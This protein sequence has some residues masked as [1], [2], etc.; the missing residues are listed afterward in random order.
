MI[1]GLIDGSATFWPELATHLWQSTLVLLVL[2]L[3]APALRGAPARLV[4]L[5]WWVALFKFFLPLSWIGRFAGAAVSALRGWAFVDPDVIVDW[6]AV[7]VWYYPAVLQVAARD[8]SSAWP[9]LYSA[10]TVIWTTG[11]ILV[12]LRGRR[13]RRPLGAPVSPCPSDRPSAT[14]RRL[15]AALKGTSIPRRSV[16]ICERPEMPHVSG[17]WRPRI[18]VS[19]A[20]IEGLD[21]DDLRAVLLHEEAHRRRRDPLRASILRLAGAL[22][23]FYPPIWWLILR[24]RETTEMAC[25]EAVLAAG[26]SADEYAGALARTLRLGLIQ[27]GNATAFHHRASSIKRRFARLNR[28]RRLVTM[29]RH[30]IALAAAVL[31]VAIASFAPIIPAGNDLGKLTPPPTPPVVVEGLEGLDR[32]VDLDFV[33]ARLEVVLETLGRQ[34]GFQVD[35]PPT[36]RNEEVSLQFDN[37]SVGQA[38]GLLGRRVGLAYSAPRP[39]HLRVDSAPLL[40]GVGDVTSPTL[41]I[42]SK[43]EPVYPESLIE[44]G[45]KGQVI[46]QAVIDETGTVGHLTVLKT[47][48]QDQ[49]DMIDSAID[50]VQQ[51]RYEPATRNGKPV[52]VYFTIFIEYNPH[53]KDD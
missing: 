35:I 43:V 29:K 14:E 31:L 30:R 39:G 10:L 50:A 47:V 17:W 1:K 42:E 48:P 41:I 13:D 18:R 24:I 34:A 26:L 28:N 7:H 51:W 6:S 4:G 22:L 19:L 53:D 25:D 46:L 37:V 16:R 49:T 32:T 15:E 36:L 5:F 45:I 44:A 8:G 3:A 20:A 38:L 33:E 23:F 27:T 11:V 40:A 21:S 2:V 52:A 12:L 9:G